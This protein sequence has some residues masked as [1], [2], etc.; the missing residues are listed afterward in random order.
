MPEVSYVTSA[1]SKSSAARSKA[2]SGSWSTHR[3]SWWMMN[4]TSSSRIR[5][6]SPCA[7][8]IVCFTVFVMT[9]NRSGSFLSV[10]PNAAAARLVASPGGFLLLRLS[11]RA[12]LRASRSAARFCL[13]SSRALA[14]A[15][16]ASRTGPDSD[17]STAA[18]RASR[19]LA[20]SRCIGFSTSGGF[21]TS[22]SILGG[23]STSSLSTAPRRR[24]RGRSV[25]GSGSAASASRAARA[26]ARSCASLLNRGGSEP[27]PRSSN[28][29][30]SAIFAL[31]YLHSAPGALITV[32]AIARDVSTICIYPARRPT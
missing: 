32:S 27:C 6:P 11:A 24:G 17:S 3:K 9:A 14:R 5:N 28:G 8:E 2:I 23:S 25:G 31:I 13:R 16:R 19:C 4:T 10:L 26:A 1:T 15:S 22:S 12:C 18:L 29:A 7:S 20:S 21:S 30:S